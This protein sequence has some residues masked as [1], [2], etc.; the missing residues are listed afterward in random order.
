RTLET[1]ETE[2][3]ASLATSWIVTRRDDRT[4][5]ALSAASLPRPAWALP[6][7]V[8]SLTVTP[9]RSCATRRLGTD[10]RYTIVILA[11]PSQL[12]GALRQR[13]RS[14]VPDAPPRR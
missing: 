8:M 4:G 5:A 1:A 9:G 13:S 7:P 10:S 14:C 3:S 12:F 6:G 2:T 11:T